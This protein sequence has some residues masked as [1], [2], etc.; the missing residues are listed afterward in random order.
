MRAPLSWLREYV[1]VD[2]SAD[3]IARRLDDLVARGSAR[4]RGRRLRHRR[5]P[6]P[7]PRRPRARGRC[8]SERRPPPRVPGGRGGG[9]RAPDRLR[10][11]ELRGRGNGRRRASRR[12]PPDPGRAA[13]RAKAA[14]RG[15][16]RDDPRR[17]RDRPR[18]GPRRDH[19]SPGRARAGNA[20]RRT[21]CRSATSCSTSPRPSTAWIS[22]RWSGSR[23]RSPRCSTASCG[24]PRSRI[25]AIVDAED[26]DVSVEDF[27]GCPRYIGR[28][29]RDVS[30]GPSPQWL[31]SRLY[32]AEM[33]SISNVVDVTN[34]VMH[35][36]GSPLHAFD[37]TKLA[38]GRIVVRRARPGEELRTLDGVAARRS[39][40]PTS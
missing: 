29:F 37:R 10:R 21:C 20:A 18:R 28:L 34:Y 38:G 5:Q 9:R 26:V 22:S 39:T 33:R 36:Y 35:V 32:L 19:G 7:L 4:V 17:G 31:R 15:L 6:R 14:R 12:A 30:I 11:L 24:F 3:E 1:D 2:A 23:A 40:R 16:A 8:A 25:P 13:R 27:S